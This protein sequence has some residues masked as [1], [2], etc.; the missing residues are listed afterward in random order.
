MIE[1]IRAQLTYANVVSTLCLFIL[2]GGSAYAA[3]KIT[4]KNVKNGSLT[5][6]DIKNNSVTGKDVKGL[7]AGDFKG[8][9]LPAGPRGPIGPRGLTGP[10]GTA[11]AGVPPTEATH[12]V[13]G[14][15]SADCSTG[16]PTG[17]FC[18]DQGGGWANAGNGTAP[19]GYFKD[20]SGIVHLQGSADDLLGSG[21]CCGNATIFIL[22][23]GYRPTGGD[24]SYADPIPPRNAVNDVNPAPRIVVKTNGEVTAYENDSGLFHPLDGVTF[25]P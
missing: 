11:G 18:K 2:L 5:G 14:D 9:A 7:G 12:L 13:T 16:S 4:G 24:R 3:A 21:T 1:R 6:T 10:R 22:P 20:R 25:R 15:G 19:V 23:A 8:G 17:V